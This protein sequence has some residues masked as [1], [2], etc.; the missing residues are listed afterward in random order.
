MT[1]WLLTV[2]IL[3]CFSLLWG[4]GGAGNDTSSFSSNSG[5]SSSAATGPAFRILGEL[6]SKTVGPTGGTI[7]AVATDGTR[8]VLT[9]PAAD[10]VARLLPP[11]NIT[12]EDLAEGVRLLDE[13]CTALDCSAFPPAPSSSLTPPL[14]A[15]SAAR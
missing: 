8:Y 7:E 11:L 12:D 6:V 15:K 14:V 1:R 3:F 9:I 5:G 4:C 13:A 10:N 2:L